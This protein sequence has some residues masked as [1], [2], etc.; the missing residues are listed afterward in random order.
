VEGI[1]QT[2]FLLFALTSVLA[3]LAPPESVLGYSYKLI[4]LHI[5]LLYVSLISLFLTL[6]FSLASLRE[7]SF[8]PRAFN[9]ALLGIVFGVGTII[10]TAAFMTMA[11]GGVVF[12]EPRFR[13]MIIT[14][15]LFLVYL[16]VHR[17]NKKEMTALYALIATLLALSSYH[18]L[19]NGSTFQLHP[20]GVTMPLKMKLPLYSSLMGFLVLY[21]YLF[22]KMEKH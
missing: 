11:W 22:E 3:F 10:V 6:A 1:L 19:V 9:A 15:G 21:Y 12:S 18:F 2:I 20:G 5:P 16:G 7:K 4:Y 14:Y 13:V 17:L 8:Y